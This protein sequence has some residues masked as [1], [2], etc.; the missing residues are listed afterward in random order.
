VKTWFSFAVLC[1]CQG[2]HVTT[3]QATDGAVDAAPSDTTSDALSAPGTWKRINPSAGAGIEPRAFAQAVWTGSSMIVWGGDD[4]GKQFSNG[5]IYDPASDSWKAIPASPAVGGYRPMVYTGSELV[6]LW[7]QDPPRDGA[8]FDLTKRTWRMIPELPSTLGYDALL[9]PV[10]VW[11]TTTSEVLMWGG[12]NATSTLSSGVAYS[13]S[14]NTWRKIAPSPL[15]ARFRASAAWN[16]ERMVIFGG[17][18]A[19]DGATYDPKTDT[20]SDVL[21]API[22]GRFDDFAL[23]GPTPGSLV[24][25]GGGSRDEDML[26]NGVFFDGTKFAEAIPECDVLTIPHRHGKT[27]WFGAGRVFMWGGISS[28]RMSVFADG[29]SYDSKTSKWSMLPKSPLGA[30]S[31]AVS[32]WT[33]SSAIVY[34][35]W[36]YPLDTRKAV[37]DD[38]AVFTP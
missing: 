37:Y 12:M 35:G 20:W 11:A 15:S 3:S 14:K 23:I 34:G 21:K 28:D 32:V 26:A 8:V 29:A 33:G 30:R 27:A 10:V 17:T 25:F 24:F 9:D 1:A 6:V 18:S 16:G 22:V 36:D 4:G 31:G 38:G 5:G 13:P 2:E 7:T 19:G